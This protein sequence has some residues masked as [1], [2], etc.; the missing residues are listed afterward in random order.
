MRIL[1]LLLFQ[2]SLF[3]IQTH[4]GNIAYQDGCPYD[5]QHT[6][7]IGTCIAIGYLRDITVG[8][9]RLKSL[10]RCTQTWG[11]GHGTIQGSHQHR[12]VVRVTCIKEGIITAK[13]HQH[14]QHD[15][16]GCQQIKFHPALA[17]TLKKAWTYLKTDTEDKEYQSE[18][19][20]E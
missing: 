16:H 2:L 7:R 13:H 8:E 11:V 5:S 3:F 4:M 1:C 10:I 15:G 17:K 14:I 12:Q 9:D 18:I 19:L 20:H 6:K